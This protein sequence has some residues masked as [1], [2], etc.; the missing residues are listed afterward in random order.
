M[1]T[2]CRNLTALCAGWAAGVD[3]V[4]ALL[5]EDDFRPHTLQV[6][7]ICISESPAAAQMARRAATL[8]SAPE[9]EK[10]GAPISAL[11]DPVPRKAQKALK[12]SAALR[13]DY[14][15]LVGDD[16]ARSGLLSVRDMANRQ[17]SSVPLTQLYDI[18]CE[19]VV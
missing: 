9:E 17:Q 19:P 11:L 16:E 2:R 13:A 7:I 4:V 1:R 12:T 15:V 3:R 6:A 18:L 10:R 5:P 8:L 14:V